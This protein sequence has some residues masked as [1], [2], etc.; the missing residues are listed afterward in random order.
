MTTS[1]TPE[2]LPA[3]PVAANHVDIDALAVSDR[4]K[5]Y[6][7]GLQNAGGLGAPA[8]KDLPPEERK[9]RLKEVQ[10]PP[11]SMILAFAFGL[12]YYI[13]KGMWKKGLVL[14]AITVPPVFILSM[15][16]Y[17]IGGETL[18]NATRFLIAAIFAYSAPRDFY[19]TKVLGDNGWLPAN[20]WKTS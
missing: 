9:L 11:V 2:I 15:I 20:P 8:L 5:A 17:F 18:A 16:L 13:A 19:A 1:T 14:L 10:P 12:L 3:A 4:W 6:F 7:K